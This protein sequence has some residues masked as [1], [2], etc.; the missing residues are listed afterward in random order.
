M[1]IEVGGPIKMPRLLKRE[2]PSALCG[3]AVAALDSSR[4]VN[5]VCLLPR[6]LRDDNLLPEAAH[7]DKR[8]AT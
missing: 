7:R 8:P 5:C 6:E 2:A 1:F 4:G 3:W